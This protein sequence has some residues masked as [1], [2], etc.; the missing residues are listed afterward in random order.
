MKYNISL[1]GKA[2]YTF[3]NGSILWY[4]KLHFYID[5]RLL[6][7]IPSKKSLK[8][9][10]RIRILSRLLRLEPRCA[11]MIDGDLCLVAFL[12]RLFVVS[13]EKQKV[14]HILSNRQA[15]GNPL[16]FCSL[17]RVG[18]NEVL[19]GDYG[20][21]P[22]LEPI[23]LYKYT[24]ENGIET[25]YTFPADSIKHVHNIL[26]DK[27][28]N[29]FFIFTGDFGDAVG[30]YVADRDFKEVKPFL[31]GSETYRAVMGK[32][33]EN[34]LLW[35]TD[36]VMHDNYVYYYPFDGELQKLGALN[37]S[38]IYGTEAGGGLVISTT[39]EPYPSK[40][41]KL[42]SILDNRKAPG[43]K[44]GDVD[45]LFIDKDLQIHKLAH[46]KKDIWP[47]RLCQY[48]YVSFPQVE[49]DSMDEIIGNP[50]AVKGYDGKE[51]YYNLRVQ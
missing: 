41:S 9:A 12:K 33:L 30:I 40:K 51:V 10:S 35:A 43:V 13:I 17:R 11:A 37:G 18:K 19:W 16:N 49:D 20:M 26:Y 39:V 22:K 27:Y 48:G 47:M 38:V 4:H 23:N 15:F 24:V 25:V 44:S 29:R 46:Y 3:D 21:N 42:L 28:R 1:K 32:V 14:E 8:I 2:L 6:C 5:N 36:S 34:G 50:M 7:S 31:T 45:V